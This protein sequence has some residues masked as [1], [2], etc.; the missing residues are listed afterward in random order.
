M[1]EKGLARTEKNPLWIPVPP[2]HHCASP[3]SHS[4]SRNLTSKVERTPVTR[5]FIP[6]NNE[7]TSQC[8]LEPCVSSESRMRELPAGSLRTVI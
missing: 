7:Q 8:V 6:E 1:G 4:A 2:P 3:A 5:G